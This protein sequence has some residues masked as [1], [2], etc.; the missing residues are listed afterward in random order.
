MGDDSVKIHRGSLQEWESFAN[1][2]PQASF[3][4][5]PL[6]SHILTKAGLAHTPEFLIFEFAGDLKAAVPALSVPHWAG[7]LQSWC[8]MPLGT[9]GGIM[10]NRHC[11][12]SEWKNVTAKVL[13]NL[14]PGIRQ[15]SLCLDLPPALSIPSESLPDR[16]VVVDLSTHLL[17]LQEDFQSLWDSRFKSNNRWSTRKAEKTGFQITELQGKEDME[18][19]Q[20]LYDGA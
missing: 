16:A 4:H 6:W 17:P 12:D 2:S 14:A 19:F 20:M 9:Y 11:S 8:S 1:K 5:T 7:L 3:F 18:L 10:T 15:P 13:Q